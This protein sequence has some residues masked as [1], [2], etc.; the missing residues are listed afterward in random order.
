M[1]S[2]VWA[3]DKQKSAVTAKSNVVVICL[4]FNEIAQVI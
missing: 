3:N 1:K 4:A 2:T